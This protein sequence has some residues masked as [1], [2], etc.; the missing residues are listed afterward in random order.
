[1]DNLVHGSNLFERDIGTDGVNHSG[2][3]LAH[4]GGIA[5]GSYYELS[6]WPRTLLEWNLDHRE[7]LV[8]NAPVVNIASHAHDLP[9]RWR[10]EFCLSGD[11]LCDLDTLAKRIHP[12]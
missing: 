5:S 4:G 6:I 7:A 8:A 11:E 1:M 9:F 2:N 3:A 12:R 10:T